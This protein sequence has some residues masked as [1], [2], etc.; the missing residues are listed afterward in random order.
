MT[1]RPPG[2]RCAAPELSG[3][4]SGE[5]EPGPGPPPA[6]VL[7]DLVHDVEHFGHP[8]D[9]VEHD[10]GA[11]RRPVD[12]FAQAL[13]PRGKLAVHLGPEEVDDECVGQHLRIHVDLPVPRGPKRK[14]D[15]RG[16]SRKRGSIFILSP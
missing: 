2:D 16:T 7:E 9:L 1:A 8:L 13:W 10:R 15:W 14:K 11:P 5:D 3:A 12:A 4:R 6:P